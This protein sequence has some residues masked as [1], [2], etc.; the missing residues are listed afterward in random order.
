MNTDALEKLFR[1]MTF[2]AT[3]IIECPG[4]VRSKPLYGGPFGQG[5]YLLASFR[6]DVSGLDAVHYIVMHAESRAALCCEETVPAALQRGREIL[7]AADPVKLNLMFERVRLAVVADQ[8]RKQAA[9]NAEYEAR[10]EALRASRKATAKSVPKRRREIFDKS[11]GKCHYC[12]SPL[13]LDGKWHI[14]HKMPRALLGGSE[15][16]NLVASCVACNM[17]KRDRTDLEFMSEM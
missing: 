3:T 11:E 10:L 5:C 13:A 1:A 8:A 16:A 9:E 15:T 7:S 4:N 12:S 17:K 6:H 14:E 2:W